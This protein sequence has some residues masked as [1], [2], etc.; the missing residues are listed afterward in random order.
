M[1]EVKA[2]KNL[3]QIAKNMRILKMQILNLCVRRLL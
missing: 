2:L 1:I 3:M